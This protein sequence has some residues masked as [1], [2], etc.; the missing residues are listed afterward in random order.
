MTAYELNIEQLGFFNDFR[1][2]LNYQDI[3]ESRQQREYRRY[4]RFDSRREHVKVIGFII[5]GRKTWGNNELNMGID[6][7]LNDVKS[8]ADRTN[9]TTGAITK[10]DTR[11]PDGKNKMNYFGLYAQHL[12]KFKNGKW[13]LN[14]G[15]RF[16]TVSLHSTIVDNS[17]FNLPVTDIKQNPFAVTGNL[18][19]IYMPSSDP[20]DR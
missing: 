7:Q 14:D 16:Q 8:V 4:D 15:I 12:L 11:Y 19:I 18:G 13:V 17:F 9:L 10:L 5:D 6:G 2:N 20:Y 3:K 1:I